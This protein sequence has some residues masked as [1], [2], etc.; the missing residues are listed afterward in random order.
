[1]KA[2]AIEGKNEVLKRKVREFWNSSV[3]GTYLAKNEEGT[4]EYYKEIEYLR[5]KKYPYA[6]AFLLKKAGFDKNKGK[7]VLEI[8]CGAG[9]DSSQFAKHGANVTGVDLTPAAIEVTKH[10]FKTMGLKGNF[11]VADA[12]NLPFKNNE[13]DY[14]YSFGVLHHTPNTQKTIDEVYRVL[15]KDGK[16]CIALYHTYSLQY[17]TLIL[18]K[19]LNPSRW[20]WSLQQAINYQTEMSKDHIKINPLTK[21]YSRSEVRKMFS[22]FKNVKTSVEWLVVPIIGKILPSFMFYPF[23]RIFGWYLIIEAEK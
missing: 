2:K 6:Y 16:A 11:L 1:M 23:S 20:K 8:G 5:Y 12:E 19:W 4:L 9:T 22:D 7:K 10:R 18:R 17:L 3:C 13:F 15:K 14:V 21:T